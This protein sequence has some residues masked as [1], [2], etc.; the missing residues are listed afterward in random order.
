[1]K[2]LRGGAR[3]G[4]WFGLNH[5][6]V[7]PDIISFAKAITSGYVPLGGIQVHDRVREVMDSYAISDRW[8]HTYTYSGH[9]VCC[10]VALANLDILESENYATGAVT[11]AIA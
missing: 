5:W 6:G 8:A 4:K 2:S 11:G 9:P 1:M 7:Q 3:T 10:A